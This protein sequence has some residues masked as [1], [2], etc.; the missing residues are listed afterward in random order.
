[1]PGMDGIGVLRA[2]RAGRA[3]PV[4]VVV[5]SAFSPAHG[6][7]AVDALAEGAFDL[8]PKPGFGEALDAFT[9]VPGRPRPRG[10]RQGARLI[11]LSGRRR[12]DLLLAGPAP[13]VG[14][15]RRIVVSADGGESFPSDAGYQRLVGR[16]RVNSFTRCS[17]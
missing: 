4:P 8:V 11:A 5:V 15:S 16:V 7:R 1:M 2:L 9:A 10:R 13:R 6:A 14:R 12:A 17:A 3:Q